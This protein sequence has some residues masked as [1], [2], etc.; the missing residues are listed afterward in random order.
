MPPTG[1][2]PADVAFRNLFHCLC[3]SHWTQ[4]QPFGRIQNLGVALDLVSRRVG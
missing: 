2:P 4:L 1:L 3:L